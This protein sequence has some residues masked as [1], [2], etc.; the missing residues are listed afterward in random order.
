MLLKFLIILSLKLFVVT[1]QQPVPRCIFSIQNGIYM[2]NLQIQNS[3]I[4]AD[5]SVIE[6]DHLEGYNDS[7]VQLVRASQQ[8]TVNVPSVICRQF[9]NTKEL[10]LILSQVQI[11]SQSSFAGCFALETLKIYYNSIYEL[12]IYTFI[13]NPSLNEVDIANNRLTRLQSGI[14]RGT[15][16]K[17]L[18]IDDNRLTTFD[19][20]WLA[21]VSGSLTYLNLRN[22]LISVLPS[23][24]F[25]QL[26]N[27]EFIDLDTNQ[28]SDIPPDAFDGLRH[29]QDLVLYKNRLTSLRPEWFITLESLQRLRLEYNEIEELPI[30]IFS[31]NNQLQKLW[32]SDNKIKVI[33][34]NSFGNLQNLE[35]IFFEFNAISAIDE[36][37]YDRAA[38]L[39][40]L[41]LYSN[42]CTSGLFSAVNNTR[43]LVRNA[44]RP[45]FDSFVPENNASISCKYEMSPEIGYT[46]T[47]TI[48]NP[49]GIEFREIPGEH[50]DN[51][52][53]E[54]VT[55]VQSYMQRTT[56]VPSVLCRQF[57]NLQFIYIAM[58]RVEEL[59]RTAFQNCANLEFLS[60]DFNDI[61]AIPDNTFSSSPHLNTMSFF[62]NRI[63]DVG[64]NA[65][66]GTKLM[67]L[68]LGSN[69][70]SSI[71]PVWF[72]DGRGDE[73]RYLLLD[74]NDIKELPSNGFSTLTNLSELILSSNPLEEVADNTFAG[75][76]NLEILNLG[77]CQLKSLHP[78]WFNDLVNLQRIY[79][80][81]NE[82]TELP[83]GIFNNVTH[84]NVA[85]NQLQAINSNSFRNVNN[86]VV[87]N[88]QNNQINEVDPN[89]YDNA[90]SLYTFQFLNNECAS[91]N[92]INLPLNREYYRNRFETCFE[93]FML[94][95]FG[96]IE[97]EYTHVEVIGYHCIM[98]IYNVRGNNNYEEI[99]GEHIDDFGNSDVVFVEA[100][101]QQT[102][103]IP[104]I[105][106]SQFVN[107]QMLYFGFN[108][109]DEIFA[110]NFD[111]CRNL[112]YLNIESNNLKII[113]EM[114]LQN[115]INLHTLT[116]DNN[117][118]AVIDENAF[119][120]TKLSILRLES[121]LLTDFNVNWFNGINETLQMLTIRNNSFT[122][123]PENSFE[124]LRNLQELEI[125]FNDLPDLSDHIFQGL[126]NLLFLSLSSCNIRDLKSSWFN[127]LTSLGSL[128][129]N[130]NHLTSIPDGIF[131]NQH[132]LYEVNFNGNRLSALNSEAFGNLSSI[133][134]ISAV[135]N[136]I[137]LIDPKLYDESD[138]LYN[139]FLFNNLCVDDNF[140]SIVNNREAVRDQLQTCFDNHEQDGFMECNYVTVPAYTCELTIQNILGRA[141]PDRIGGKHVDNQNDS[142][143]MFVEALLQH[144]SSFPSIICRQFNNLQYI[145]LLESKLE[146]LTREAFESCTNL[147][148]LFLDQNEI[149]VIPDNVL[150]PSPT[151]A[152]VSF[153]SNEVNQIHPN[154]F[155]GTALSYINL[156]GN[157]LTIINPDWFEGTIGRNLMYFMISSNN[158]ST[159][160][161]NSFPNLPKI[162]EISLSSNPLTDIA[163]DA[164]A[165]LSALEILELENCGIR[166]LDPQWFSDLSSLVAVF[167]NENQLTELPENVFGNV[168]QIH[169]ANNQLQ[170]IDANAFPN[171]SS[172]ILFNG[173]NNQINEIDPIFYND[174]QSLYNL[175]LN[176]NICVSIDIMN[177]ALNRE[178]YRPMFE[179]CFANFEGVN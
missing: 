90:E 85:N 38:N 68:N 121:N 153:F 37:F 2:C 136:R 150:P 144:T 73:M 139:L 54:N 80:N 3:D 57:V 127:D 60:L 134:Y 152:W 11:V 100:Y 116:L 84:V 25:V 18:S 101:Q 157:R 28:L 75:L 141:N 7:S 130:Y 9:S 62:L 15:H 124:N 176:G 45:C 132:D 171:L 113:P 77:G 110:G 142:D 103:I 91:L 118:I 148:V 170:R 137:S 158:I 47:M 165:G 175:Q 94:E 98:S 4:A 128:F 126:S 167:L 160:H 41:Y 12:P 49:S 159:L 164:F 83:V 20:A 177:L 147:D 138:N 179:Q 86:L 52:S 66:A 65:F 29:L 117:Q 154:A 89:L 74:R 23:Q 88:A 21:D 87:L 26:T 96:F 119:T 5:F 53:D 155:A 50:V 112:E 168:R 39:Y 163:S 70:I 72:E 30:G 97:C 78:Q 67:Y 140:I 102:T 79:I 161:S 105:I 61:R 33:D 172:L 31:S 58:C 111:D 71:N 123:L 109:V 64:P 17:T 46:C 106:C 81:Q 6:G 162:F 122:S 8:T 92:I 108:G 55:M 145:Y 107:L 93:N 19:G 34:S 24:A 131:N 44:L 120:G 169:V 82:L 16:L 151:L 1:G 178:Y 22:N 143:V 146:V 104:S 56:I 10:I 27:L 135:N 14:F 35:G 40:Y 173:R 133:L 166:T 69:H 129:L 42:N 99:E 125:G 149:R 63:N 174:T 48:D 156:D 51:L 76:E 114:M 32:M 13:N 115:S 43:D 95:N 59:T 36:R